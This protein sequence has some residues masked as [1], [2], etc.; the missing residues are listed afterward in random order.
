MTG[1]MST[2]ANFR[3]RA[4][5]AITNALNR[6]PIVFGRISVYCTISTVKINEKSQM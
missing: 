4:V 6:T 2:I 1:V 3:M 5:C